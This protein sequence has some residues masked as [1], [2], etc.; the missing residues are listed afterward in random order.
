MIKVT[1]HAIDQFRG[2]ILLNDTAEIKLVERQIK[3]LFERSK[4]IRDNQK[5]ILFRNEELMIEFIVKDRKIVTLFPIYK[6]KEA[7]HGAISK[8][9]R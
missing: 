8:I 3:N 7:G 6:R 1:K 2:R 5:G 4:Y 9:N